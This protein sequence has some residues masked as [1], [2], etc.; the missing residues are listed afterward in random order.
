MC[1]RKRKKKQKPN[2]LIVMHPAL[3]LDNF[4]PPLILI[5]LISSLIR[6]TNIYIQIQF[7]SKSGGHLHFPPPKLPFATNVFVFCLPPCWLIIQHHFSQCGC[8]NVPA[9]TKDLSN[10]PFGVCRFACTRVWNNQNYYSIPSASDHL[11]TQFSVSLQKLSKFLYV[12]VK[13]ETKHSGFW[14]TDVDTSILSRRQLKL[15]CTNS[16]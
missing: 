14:Q 8:N 12:A 5:W 9:K 6:G 1:Q 16:P 15:S 11:L 13:A 2:Y 4:L 7:E 10:E 3:S